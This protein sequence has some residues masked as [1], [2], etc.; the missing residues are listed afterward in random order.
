MQQI[1]T[2]PVFNSS[3]VPVSSPLCVC[4]DSAQ[5]VTSIST[6]FGVN[7]NKYLISSLSVR[8]VGVWGRHVCK[9]DWHAGIYLRMI[10]RSLVMAMLK[11]S[12]DPW[13]VDRC[14]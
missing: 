7:N 11:T 12:C 8:P 13:Q 2:H 10:G 4:L 1:T 6:L 9:S 5:A 14:I 3:I